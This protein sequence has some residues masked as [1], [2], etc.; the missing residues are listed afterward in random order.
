LKFA[1]QSI[2]CA[3]DKTQIEDK[4]LP[5][6]ETF[7]QSFQAYKRQ[8]RGTPNCIPVAPIFNLPE[9]P[10]ASLPDPS[11]EYA[12]YKHKLK[13]LE[14]EFYHFDFMIVLNLI[15]KVYFGEP[16]CHEMVKA[17]RKVEKACLF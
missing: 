13:G 17:F 11:L 14:S 5:I 12:L 1:E 9:P 10:A 3:Q 7:S 8:D 6:A 4:F 16:T 2:F 15:S